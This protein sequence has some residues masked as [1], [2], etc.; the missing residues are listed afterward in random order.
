MEL[1]SGMQLNLGLLEM[2]PS[3]LAAVF[4]PVFAG[5]FMA[6]FLP[7]ILKRRQAR[8]SEQSDE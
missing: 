3:K 1:F 4:I 5:V 7:V 8:D 6:V 2:E